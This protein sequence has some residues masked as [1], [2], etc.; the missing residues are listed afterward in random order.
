MKIIEEIKNYFKKKRLQKKL[1][2]C[3]VEALV[4]SYYYKSEIYVLRS[5]YDFVHVR[6]RHLKNE[7]KYN[8]RAFRGKPLKEI[9]D[10]AIV[11]IAAGAILDSRV[12]LDFAKLENA[13]AAQITAKVVR[14]HKA[15]IK[16]QEQKE[17]K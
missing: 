9:T 1:D 16:K 3:V 4:D 7:K 11:T 14:R 6:K 8:K 13:A 10:N 12:D 15:K 17:R 5:G 2:R